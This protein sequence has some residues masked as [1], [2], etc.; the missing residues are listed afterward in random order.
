MRRSGQD[1]ESGEDDESERESQRRGIE[2][3]EEE[4]E[5]YYVVKSI[6]CEKVDPKRV[7]MRDTQSYCG[8]LLDDN[9]RK[10]ICRLRFNSSQKYVGLFDAKKNESKHPIDSIDEIYRFSEQLKETAVRYDEEG[11]DDPA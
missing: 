9:N 7:F 6:V 5:G 2:T 4:I 8:V 11:D 10:P 3:T 1:T